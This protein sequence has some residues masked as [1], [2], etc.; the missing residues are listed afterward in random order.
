MPASVVLFDALEDAAFR[1]VNDM[2][3]AGTPA[4]ESTFSKLKEN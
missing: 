4:F 2:H 1:A 3:G